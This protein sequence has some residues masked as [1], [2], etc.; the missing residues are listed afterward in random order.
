MEIKVTAENFAAE[1]EN[2]AGT[3]LLDFGAP[4]CGYCKMLEPELAELAEEWEAEGKELTVAKIDVDEQPELAN[5]FG[6]QGIPLLVVYRDGLEVDRAAGFRPK[7]AIA[8]ML[9]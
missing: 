7:D 2:A 3:V 6:V 8:E 4:W 5:R 1:V 9:E